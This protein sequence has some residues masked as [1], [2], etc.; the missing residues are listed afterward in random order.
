MRVKAIALVM[1]C[2]GLAFC[3]S[4]QTKVQRARERDPKYQYNLGLFYLNQSDTD[5]AVKYFIKS[6]TL[7]TRYYPA[8]NAL[9]LAHS[10]RG[11]LDESAKAYQ[12]CLEINPRFTEAHNNL[13][14]VY[15]G[16]NQLDKAEEEFRKALADLTYQNR[17]LP[18]CNLARLYVIQDRLD[19][20]LENADKALQIRPRLAMAHNIKGQIL[21]KKNDLDGAVVSYEAAVKIVPDDLLFNYNLGAACFRNGEYAR[22]REV[23]LKIRGKITDADMKETIARYLRLIGEQK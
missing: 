10:M 22:S 20:A 19:E 14:T 15:Q 23:F 21:E 8:W 5:N 2:A 13:G 16:M 6:L 12:K 4:S 11:R 17:E 3:A 1:L 9:G 18:Y 7:D